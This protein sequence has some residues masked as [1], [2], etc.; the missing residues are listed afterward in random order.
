MSEILGLHH[1]TSVG[2]D[3]GRR[4]EFYTR[5]PGLRLVKRTANL[6]EPSVPHT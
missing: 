4:L 3:A 2:A 6:D 5:T 1:V